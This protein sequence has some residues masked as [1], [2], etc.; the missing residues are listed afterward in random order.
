[1][2]TIVTKAEMAEWI[3]DISND[4]VMMT[5]SEPH[6]RSKYLNLELS[7]MEPVVN[8][9]IELA[10]KSVFGKHKRF[11]ALNGII[12]C[13]HVKS[14]PHFHIIFQKPVDK[15]F[16]IFK[17]KLTKLADR[18]CDSRFEF[19]LTDSYLPARVK[20]ALTKPCYDRFV[21]VTNAHECTGSYLTKE[22]AHYYLLDGRK[23]VMKESQID[24][25]VD[26]NRSDKDDF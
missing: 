16:E 1:M 12:V 11:D 5:I 6:A 19:N 18:L 3:K 15:E 23:L 7:H 10:S 25:Y 14:Q 4:G 20:K 22:Y 13:E 26:F 2:K 21:R 9:I 8:R 17:S 24:L